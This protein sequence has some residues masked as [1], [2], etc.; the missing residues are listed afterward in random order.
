M[1]GGFHVTYWYWTIMRCQHL[2][3]PSSL[4]DASFELSGKSVFGAV[5]I[6]HTETTPLGGGPER[7]WQ[8]AR[9]MLTWRITPN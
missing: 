2:L 8:P 6:G 7:K 9:D 3:M 1:F 5:R 4:D